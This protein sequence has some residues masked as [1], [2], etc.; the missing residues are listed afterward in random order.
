MIQ[1]SILI[2]NRHKRF[3]KAVCNSEIVWGLENHEGFASSKSVYYEDDDGEPIGI[4]CFWGEKALATSCIKDRW[5]KYK[6]TEISL[7]DFMENWCVG[8]GNDRLLIGTEFDQNLFGFEADPY[9]LILDLSS[10]LKS[11]GKDL[12]FR[13]FNGVNDLES[14]VKEAIE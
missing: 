11:I 14:Q 6:T 4:I 8:M 3:I 12:N 5:T 9:E 1:D 10:E 7:S 2:E 13:K